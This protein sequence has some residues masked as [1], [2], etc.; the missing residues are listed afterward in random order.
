MSYI[1]AYLP[2]ESLHFTTSNDELNF[3][4]TT[5][6]YD[7]WRDDDGSAAWIRE[8]NNLTLSLLTPSYGGRQHV[9]PA[10]P[11][12]LIDSTW[13]VG[14]KGMV[15]IKVDNTDTPVTS[16][17]LR[18]EISRLELA[19]DESGKI[20]D[21]QISDGAVSATPNSVMG[22]AY[23]VELNQIT[24]ISPKLRRLLGYAG[25]NQVLD[26]VSFDNAGNTTEIRQRIFDTAANAA[27]APQ[28]WPMTIADA[29][30]RASM[31]ARTSRPSTS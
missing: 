2:G 23:T 14:T 13:P 31:R 21:Q 18:F 29:S 15:V 16:I 10:A 4:P 8:A 6:F 19:L 7:V 5:G 28:S 27:A 12:V 25:E 26:A 24:N 1:G 17:L 22:R 20:I 3:D 11:F 30:P 9:S